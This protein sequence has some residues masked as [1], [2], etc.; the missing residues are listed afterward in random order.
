MRA[1]VQLPLVFL[2]IL[3]FV[4]V[5]FASNFTSISLN[6][7]IIGG[8]W[9]QRVSVRFMAKSNGPLSGVRLYWLIANPAGHAGLAS[10]TGGKLDYAL[11]TDSNGQ[12]R[13]VLATA[14]FIQNQVTEN[15]RGNFP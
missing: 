6:N 12:A 7:I 11:R 10:G 4:G 14:S 5:L 15:Q 8:Q 9:S 2:Y 13:R 1:K 3:G